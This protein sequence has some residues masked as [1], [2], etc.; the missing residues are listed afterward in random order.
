[1]CSQIFDILTGFKMH[2]LFVFY[3]LFVCD[4]KNTQPQNL[5]MYCLLS[6]AV[7]K[8]I[9]IPRSYVDADDKTRPLPKTDAKYDAHV[10]REG[11]KKLM[12]IMPDIK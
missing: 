10:R 7:V 1:M 11:Y 9:P 3:C 2:K 6:H 8:N 4:S 5:R 12:M